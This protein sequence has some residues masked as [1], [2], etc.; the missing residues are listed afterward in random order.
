MKTPPN[1]LFNI[2]AQELFDRKCLNILALDVKEISSITDSILIVEGNVERHVSALAN[3]VIE[4]LEEHG[5]S[6]VY[7]EGKDEGDW[8][9]I[10]YIDFMIHIFT[11]DLRE[12]Y[13]LEVLWNS[14][15]LINLDLRIPEVIS[16]GTL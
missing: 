10:D 15:R 9:I 13:Q 8:V 2:A 6:P 3:S 1:E 11:P 5:E 4:K 12:R 7:V 14:G 16:N